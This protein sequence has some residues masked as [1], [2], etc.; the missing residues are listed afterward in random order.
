MYVLVESLPA[1]KFGVHLGDVQG[2]EE[3]QIEGLEPLDQQADR[4]GLDLYVLN[5]FFC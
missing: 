3:D 5:K 4:L 1:L 2:G